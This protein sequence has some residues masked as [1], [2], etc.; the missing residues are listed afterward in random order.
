MRHLI[1]N[2]D[3]LGLCRNVNKAIFEL[4]H[5]KILTSASLLVDGK[6]AQEAVMT[7]KKKFPNV[8]LG[9]HFDFGEPPF[10]ISKIVSAMSNQWSKFNQLTGQVPTHVDVRSYPGVAIQIS[11]FLP[12]RVPVRNVG[13]IK[14]IDKFNGSNGEDAVSLA[15][16]IK[17][18]KRVKKGIYELSCQPGYEPIEVENGDSG[19][20]D[21]GLRERALRTLLDKRFKMILDIRNISLIS[22]FDLLK[23]ERFRVHILDRFCGQFTIAA[24]I[25][26][27]YLQFIRV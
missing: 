23:Q 4:C 18:L 7:M 12:E 9:L 27:Y 8:S 3:D 11:R 19:N 26:I 6:T 20:I 24:L 22:Y 10:Q 1:V 15:N 21:Y 14:H 2:G 17:I 16:L 5:K 25:Q 13:S